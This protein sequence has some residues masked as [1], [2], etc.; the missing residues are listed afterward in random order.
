[1]LIFGFHLTACDFHNTAGSAGTENAIVHGQQ[2]RS[3]DALASSVVAILTELP[4]GQSLCTGSIL[5]ENSVLTA[6]HCVDGHTEKMTI[7]FAKN[8]R[9][10]NE[11]SQRLVTGFVQNPYWK[12]PNTNTQGD[13]A[14]IHFAGGLPEGYKPVRLAKPTEV[15]SEGQQVYFLGYG[16][17][18]GNSQKGSGILRGT[19]SRIIGEQSPTETITDGKKSSVCF[20]DSGGPA[21]I[22]VKNQ[23]V[24]WGVASS[25]FN[26]ACNEASIHTNVMP[27]D[28]WIRNEA[29]F[30]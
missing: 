2:A 20:G 28:S 10:S 1:M 29:Q 8:I 19:T 30:R 11:Y 18:N 15:V 24:Q 16:V 26:Q 25:V 9:Q 13:L 6:A 21:F 12:H 7:V 17:T 5:N 27:Y 14:I 4:E 22:K 23:F 3:G